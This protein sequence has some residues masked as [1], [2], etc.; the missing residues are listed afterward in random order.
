[1]KSSVHFMDHH[2]KNRK[3]GKS[4]SVEIFSHFYDEK[5]FGREEK[6]FKNRFSIVHGALF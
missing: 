2:E 6:Y 3:N 4:L 1:M 5:S